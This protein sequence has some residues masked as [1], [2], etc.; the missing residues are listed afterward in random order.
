MISA[1]IYLSDSFSCIFHGIAG[2]NGKKKKS[3]EKKIGKIDSKNVRYVL[4]KIFAVKF[5]TKN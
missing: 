5:N 2:K 1:F 4:E 3:F